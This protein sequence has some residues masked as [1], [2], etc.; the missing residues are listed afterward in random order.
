M[1][2]PDTMCVVMSYCA[3]GDMHQLIKARAESGTGPHSEKLVLW[4]LVQCLLAL[5]HMHDRHVLHRDLK[6]S[7]IFIIPRCSSDSHASLTFEPHYYNS[8]VAVARYVLWF[9]YSQTAMSHPCRSEVDSTFSL[10]K[11]GDFGMARAMKDSFELADSCV[12]TPAYMS[13]EML[14]NQPYGPGSDMWSMGCCLYQMMALKNAFVGVSI[15]KTMEMIVKGNRPQLSEAWPDQPTIYSSGLVAM[16][17][18][19]L[20]S[21]DSKRPTAAD[22]LN[23]PLL[24]RSLAD[25]RSILGQQMRSSSCSSSTH[26][27]L[28]GTDDGGTAGKG[29]PSIAWDG[30]LDAMEQLLATVA[31]D[32]DADEPRLPSRTTTPASCISAFELELDREASKLHREGP[33]VGDTENEDKISSFADQIPLASVRMFCFYLEHH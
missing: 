14:K 22:M 30:D 3:G 33:T 9:T 25:Y 15:A 29:A 10:L 6:T 20:Q 18:G 5:R 13:P 32:Q 7:N 19:L 8:S 21:D 24:N 2:V 27:P 12:G 11:L 4:W 31:A 16:V 17:D 23:D 1:K 28:Q 26:S